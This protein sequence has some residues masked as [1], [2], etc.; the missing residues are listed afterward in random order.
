VEEVDE[1]QGD[2]IGRMDSFF[3]NYVAHILGYFFNGLRNALI[4]SLVWLQFGH[5]LSPFSDCLLWAV[6]LKIAV[7]CSTHFGRLFP[8][9]IFTKM[10]WATIWAI[11]SQ[12]SSGHPDEMTCNNFLG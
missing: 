2:Q 7:V 1:M 8:R 9:L 12:N 4:L 10:G 11:L 5:F 3:D 6:F